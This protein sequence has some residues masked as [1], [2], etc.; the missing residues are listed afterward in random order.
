MIHPDD[1]INATDGFEDNER[2]RV[3]QAGN[4]AQLMGMS[5]GD[6]Y[7]DLDLLREE[8]GAKKARNPQS[9]DAF[10]TFNE[11]APH[12]VDPITGMDARSYAELFHPLMKNLKA[13]GYGFLSGAA[14]GAA[15]FYNYLDEAADFA[16]RRTGTEKGQLFRDWTRIA[17][18]KGEYWQT[19]SKE[20][21]IT[22]IAEFV[23]NTVGGLVPGLTEFMLDKFGVMHGMAGATKAYGKG[24][25]ETLGFLKGAI[26]RNLMGG[27]L[28]QTASLSRPLRVGA[29]GGLFEEQARMSGA[30]EEDRLKAFITGG[31]FGLMGGEG[32]ISL[33]DLRKEMANVEMEARAKV[34]EAASS[35]ILP[36]LIRNEIGLVG[37]SKVGSYFESNIGAKVQELGE[38]QMP[39]DEWLKR[40]K[41]WGDKFKG[42]KEESHWHGVEAFLE[43]KGKDKVSRE[44]LLEFVEGTKKAWPERIEMP[45][46]KWADRNVPGGENAKI[47][48]I[49][50]PMPSEGRAELQSKYDEVAQKNRTL[51]EVLEGIEQ[52]N[53]PR[54]EWPPDVV[55]RWEAL[56]REWRDASD[57]AKVLEQ[58]Y[59]DKNFISSHFHNIPNVVMHI[60]TQE[61]RDSQ[62]R[63]GLLAETIQSDWHQAGA[64]RGYASVSSKE[65]AQIDQD[66]KSAIETYGEDR[67]QWPEDV[68]QTVMRGQSRLEGKMGVPDAP[69]KK[70][71][72]E[73]G[74]KQLIDIA[75]KDPSIEWVG[76][77]SGEVQNR[78][79]GKGEHVDLSEHPVFDAHYDRLMDEFAEKHN[80]DPNE[81]EE[82]AISDKAIDL[83]LEEIGEKTFLEELYDQRLPKFASKYVK[84]WGS[85]VEK[86]KITGPAMGG[87][88]EEWYRFIYRK[89]GDR[90]AIE[91]ERTGD[92]RG[93]V[94]SELQAGIEC[95]TPGADLDLDNFSANFHPLNKSGTKWEINIPLDRGEIIAKATLK[96]ISDVFGERIAEQIKSDLQEFPDNFKDYGY[97]LDR[98]SAKQLLGTGGKEDQIDYAY[99]KIPITS[100]MRGEIEAKG[101]VLYDITNPQWVIDTLKL[102]QKSGSKAMPHLKVLGEKVWL[103]GKTDVNSWTDAMASILQF[104]DPKHTADLGSVW[105]SMQRDRKRRI[106]ENDSRENRLDQ[107][108]KELDKFTTYGGKYNVNRSRGEDSKYT[109]GAFPEQYDT[110]AE[111][112]D[113][114]KTLLK[115]DPEYKNLVKEEKQL[116]KERKGH[117]L[118]YPSYSSPIPGAEDIYHGTYRDLVNFPD[119]PFGVHFGTKEQATSRITEM[120]ADEAKASYGNA[121]IIKGNRPPGNYLDVG[122]E[123]YEEN[124]EGKRGFWDRPGYII[125]QLRLLEAIDKEGFDRDGELAVFK[126]EE[127]NDLDREVRKTKGPDNKLRKIKEWLQNKGY[128]GI[129]YGN[130]IEDGRS[131]DTSY[132]IFDP[133]KVP[134][135]KREGFSR[136]AD[137]FKP[138][139]PIEGGGVTLY[140]V[141]DPRWI[142]D[143]LRKTKGDL[144]A[145]KPHLIELGRYVRNRTT[146]MKEWIGGMEKSLGD[147]WE[148]YLPAMD[149]VWSA[150]EA[151]AMQERQKYRPAIE[152][153]GKVYQANS[154]THGDVYGSIPTEVLEGAKEIRT[155][156]LNEGNIFLTT[157][158]AKA[159]ADAK[160]KEELATNANPE[161][162]MATWADDIIGVRMAG[163]KEF[164]DHLAKKRD[165][166]MLLEEARG[167]LDQSIIGR[168]KSIV[169][170][171][172]GQIKVSDLVSMREDDALRWQLTYA[173]RAAR[174]AFSVGR[175]EGKEAGFVEGA[176]AGVRLGLRTGRLESREATA[177]RFLAAIERAKEKAAMRK[178]IREIISDLKG[179]DSSHLTDFARAEW[180]ALMP[181]LDMAT[182][183][184]PKRISLEKTRQFLERNP[185]TELPEYVLDDLARLDKVPIREL[186][187]DEMRSV[188]KAMMSAVAQS[189]RLQSIWVGREKRIAQETVRAAVGDMKEGPEVQRDIISTQPNR[190]DRFLGL[191]HWIRTTLGLRQD[192]FDLI[193]ETLAGPGSVMYRVLY[194]NVK[195]GVIKQKE[196]LQREQ[197]LFQKTLEEDGFYEHVDQRKVLKWLDERVTVGRLSLSRG[198]RMALYRHSLNEDNR[199]AILE[200]GIGFKN[201]PR[202]SGLTP[203]KPIRLTKEELQEQVA[204][205]DAAEKIFAGRAMDQIFE[206]YGKALNDEFYRL[207][208]W[209]FERVENY[210]PK[211]VMPMQRGGLDLE[212][213]EGLESFRQFTAR[214]GIDKSMLIRRMGSQKPIYLNDVMTDIAQSASRS[215]AYLGLEDPMRN[216]SRLL[217]DAQFK[218]ELIDRYGRDVWVELEKGLKDIAGNYR[219]WS[220]TEKG[221]MRL[222]TNVVGSTLSANLW[223]WM[224]Q[225][226]SLPM[227]N[228]Y[229]E[230]RHINKAI[231]DLAPPSRFKEVYEEIRQYSPEL[232]DR[233]QGGYDRDLESSF[234]P[235]REHAY[236]NPHP[237]GLKEKLLMPTKYMD[238]MAVI[239]GMR[240]SFFKAMEELQTGRL[241]NSVRQALGFRVPE[242]SEDL[243][244][245]KGE[246]KELTYDKTLARLSRDG[247]EITLDGMVIPA[248]Y[249]DQGRGRAFV[250]DLIASNPKVTTL[251]AMADDS[252]KA[253][254]EKLGF[255]D[256]GEGT[257]QTGTSSMKLDTRDY[258]YGVD[259]TPQGMVAQAWKYADWTTERTQ[260]Q[261]SME[262]RSAMT[263]G[264]T[265]EQFLT[266]YGSQTNA[267]LNLVRRTHRE[268]QRT[269]DPEDRWAWQKAVFQVFVVNALGMGAIDQLRDA[270][271]DRESGSWVMKFVENASATIFILRDI[272][273]TMTSHLEKGSRGMESKVP[274]ASYVDRFKEIADDLHNIGTSHNE[275]VIDEAW[276]GLMDNIIALGMQGTGYPYTTPKK[277]AQSV[278]GEEKPRKKVNHDLDFDDIILGD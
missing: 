145:A 135:V 243:Q 230:A 4:Y 121:Q 236:Y 246:S 168:M 120:D 217:Y 247:D 21:G 58:Q 139:K 44:E 59:R 225:I 73:L 216:A 221:L 6:A 69:F 185:D 232:V 180:E 156:W 233:V 161:P 200:G 241:S 26:E 262:H 63:K 86:D 18:E 150:V 124:W 50:L 122:Y 37:D 223:I 278:F 228:T 234:R 97:D 199:A 109:I 261:A 106:K 159:E 16:A 53:G 172:T 177:E 2:R 51:Y 198:E 218:G 140:S 266:A 147:M 133:S 11:D 174:K 48:A 275:R 67:G 215:S 20:A 209:R 68:L 204:S 8:V 54:S 253:F 38:G 110:F 80:R 47:W 271:Y 173:A 128:D 227:Y 251:R 229:V 277:I 165:I 274:V 255:R 254:F 87:M 259:L 152:I 189:D 96:D 3:L 30:S 184:S 148:S 55:D 7:T 82:E 240:A 269:G 93:H 248:E 31:A 157:E 195:E 176:Q 33:S 131:G 15:S 132:I 158:A 245:G 171:A 60:R 276:W 205:L 143:T 123:E 151:A 191:S 146:G 10:S 98:L 79:W 42:I 85:G 226:V 62:G 108:G 90:W 186:T 105:L 192:S 111:A 250:E 263:R 134:I 125:N 71:W 187:M 213:E 99:H 214:I 267:M 35:D 188:H 264:G 238:L 208:K 211:D 46:D 183:S 126:P 39:G 194:G 138:A 27:I 72:P 141:T 12:G 249:R 252:S 160:G 130:V 127:L 65:R 78:R 25:D 182:L 104:M 117:G 162:E 260:A 19:M 181:L 190:W 235:Y 102:I 22:P 270:L 40:V 83:T 265:L 23:T 61:I 224:N 56:H 201:P 100:Q 92:L 91:D 89:T 169:R 237:Q 84:K 142:I 9:F 36:R 17:M 258:R 43:S 231:A 257:L 5:Q 66:M 220:T 149:E 14:T 75:M 219:A 112:Y 115:K 164:E 129:A 107:I 1:V 202:S 272:V 76:W 212:S 32:K 45:D 179:V 29:I 64:D 13:Q 153:D 155:G 144:E 242:I 52:T 206:N 114:S 94:D 34:K 57:E 244:I 154:G 210:Y 222:K 196:I 203:N 239:P 77:S 74:V 116:L 273:K 167:L 113:A 28:H 103:S 101:Q 118:S 163:R 119:L 193:C 88:E 197:A 256:T 175:V 41:A 24:E 178:E 170:E 268:Y 95:V 166:W 137:D 81:A 207:N 136:S 49:K 70:T